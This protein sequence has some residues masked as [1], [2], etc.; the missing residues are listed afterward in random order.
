[1]K[2]RALLSADFS[3][4]IIISQLL[5]SWMGM[6]DTFFKV[7]FRKSGAPFSA[8][9]NYAKHG[10]LKDIKFSIVFRDSSI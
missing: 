7:S 5:K 10:N 9:D 4:E 2:K 1:M 6:Q 3:P 8:R